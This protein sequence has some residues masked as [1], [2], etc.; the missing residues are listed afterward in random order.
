MLHLLSARNL[1][2]PPNE[3]HSFEALRTAMLRDIQPLNS[4]QTEF[5]NAA[6]RASWTLQRCDAAERD[7]GREL[8]A[9]PLLS[10]DQRIAR[11]YRIRAQALREYRMA[12]GELRRLQTDHAIRRLKENEGLAALPAPIDANSYI[13][14]A[15]AAGGLEK[16]QRLCFPPIAARL[17][18]FFRERG[19]GETAWE[20]W[21]RQQQNEATAA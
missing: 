3:R 15:R 5:F 8:D 11:L 4:L 16:K 1:H 13:V 17:D 14:A 7:L 20:A 18:Q 10:K 9:D 12:L 2:V 21:L 19:Q 6:L